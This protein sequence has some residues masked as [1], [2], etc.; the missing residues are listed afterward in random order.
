MCG[1]AAGYEPRR[2]AFWHKPEAINRSAD[3]PWQVVFS[4]S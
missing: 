2:D 3:S 1:A 4:C